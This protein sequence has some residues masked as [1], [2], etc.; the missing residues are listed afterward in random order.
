[1]QTVMNPDISTPI[2][3]QLKEQLARLSLRILG[4][5]L[6]TIR[7][8]GSQAS[9]CLCKVCEE[10]RISYQIATGGWP[11]TD[12]EHQAMVDWPGK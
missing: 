2:I 5:H 11:T 7:L 3:R 6:W 8:E 12:E 4:Q 10:A 9:V 1:M